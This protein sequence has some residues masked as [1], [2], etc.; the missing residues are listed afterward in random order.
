MT[1]D[2]NHVKYKTEFNGKMFYFCSARCKAQFKKNMRNQ[3]PKKQTRKRKTGKKA[4]TRKGIFGE[5]LGIK[6]LI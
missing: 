5:A 3:T 6:S 1:I 4:A 2:E